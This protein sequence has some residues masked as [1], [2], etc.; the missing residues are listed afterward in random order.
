MYT[1]Q[2]DSLSSQYYITYNLIY[3]FTVSQRGSSILPLYYVHPVYIIAIQTA[4]LSKFKLNCAKLQTQEY[5]RSSCKPKGAK[6]QSCNF[7]GAKVD[8]ME[9]HA[10][11]VGVLHH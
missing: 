4:K 10:S 8:V 6:G 9:L 2:H 7:K 3:K 11:S 5:K 1:L